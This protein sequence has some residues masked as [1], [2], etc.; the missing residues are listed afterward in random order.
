MSASVTLVC[1]VPLFVAWALSRR[2][3]RAVPKMMADQVA[4]AERKRTD[5]LALV[6]RLQLVE[7]EVVEAYG[8]RKKSGCGAL[9]RMIMSRTRD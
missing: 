6:S 2:E 9:R 4:Q 3:R 8:R 5:F 7:A 1:L